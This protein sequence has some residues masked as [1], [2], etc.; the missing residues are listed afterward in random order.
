MA[1]FDG[2]VVG[3]KYFFLLKKSNIV[4]RWDTRGL[5]VIATVV[6]GIYC[7][8][9]WAEIVREV[10]LFFETMSQREAV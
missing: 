2:V 4:G 9:D 8:V 6:T 1:F 5:A 10:R 7:D 3:F